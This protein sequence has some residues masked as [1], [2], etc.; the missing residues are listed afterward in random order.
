[1]D[2]ELKLTETLAILLYIPMKAKR[3][4][5]NGKTIQDKGKV[6]M[7]LSYFSEFWEDLIKLFIDPD[8]EKIKNSE[9]EESIKPKLNQINKFLGKKDF[10][11]GY[12]TVVDFLFWELINLMEKLYTK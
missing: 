5:L 2:G 9:F 12:I 3:E 1:M 7:L 10:L 8:F 4:D 6:L 11:L